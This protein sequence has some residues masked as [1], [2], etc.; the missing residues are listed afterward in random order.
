MN[1]IENY[2]E[3][4]NFLVRE[5]TNELPVE[6]NYFLSADLEPS[7][8]VFADTIMFLSRTFTRIVQTDLFLRGYA[9][10]PS[11]KFKAPAEQN[12]PEI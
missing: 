9:T 2:N 7:D 11:T 10:N 8:S 1:S 5:D 4:K 3:Q 12:N 6:G